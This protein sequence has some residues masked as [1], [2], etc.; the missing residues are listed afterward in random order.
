MTPTKDQDQEQVVRTTFSIHR[1][2]LFRLD[3]VGILIKRRAKFDAA[4]SKLIAAAAD[5]FYDVKDEID[6]EQV[7]DEATLRRELALAIFRMIEREREQQSSE[8]QNV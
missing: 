8:E 7:R 6:Y 2:T 4:R 3:D 5:L 1:S